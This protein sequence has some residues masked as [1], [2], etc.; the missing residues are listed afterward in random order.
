MENRSGIRKGLDRLYLV[1]GWIGATFIA[2]ICLLVLCQVT[3]NAIDRLSG[4]IV[5]SAIGLT[6]PSYADFTG[7]FLAAASF[8]AL[9]YTLR[10]GEHI[11]VTL[12]LSHCSV[13]VRRWLEIWCLTLTSG[14]SVYFS[15]YS[16]LLVRESYIYHDLSPGMI[17]V[18]IWI[19]Q[20][21]MFAGL[22]ILSVALLDSLF[23]LFVQPL[24]ADEL[25]HNVE[26]AS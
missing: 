23:S 9:A 21:A 8:M 6:I 16:F 13:R 24:G 3:L 7:F 12:F 22:V 14:V 5:G 19:P 26:E 11:R 17:A 10:E 25:A 2:L 18:P 1:S 15:W 20:A 4:L